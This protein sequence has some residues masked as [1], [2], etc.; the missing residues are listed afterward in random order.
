MLENK[1]FCAYILCFVFS[2][3]IYVVIDKKNTHSLHKESAC[4]QTTVKNV[5]LLSVYKFCFGKS[6]IEKM[7]ISS[8]SLVV[9]I[10]LH[11]R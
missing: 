9:S 7:F 11:D 3:P 5:N 10:R 1:D 2:E 4:S 6:N 8:D